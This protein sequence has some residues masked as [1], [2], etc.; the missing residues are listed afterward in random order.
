[1]TNITIEDI[2][3][4]TV[5]GTGVFD[6][7]MNAVKEHIKE[8]Y[9]NGRIK[10]TDYAQVYLGAL[11]GVLGQSVEYV[12]REK[13]TEAQ[14]EGAL[15]DI[16]LKEAQIIGSGYDNQVKQQQVAESVFR[17]NNMLPKELEQIT[18]QI[19]QITAQIEDIA[20]G[21][22][23]KDMQKQIAYVERVIKDKEATTMGL[24]N[25]IRL[26]EEARKQD[27]NYV[28][29]PVYKEIG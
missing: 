9:A 22:E 13:L 28:Y 3:T 7:L 1:M 18:A 11:Q 8:E 24:D 23:I 25:A 16:V 15:K 29:V 26:R 20:K 4:G 12:L 5:D 10:G 27:T 14:V 17:V 6:K 19:E 2:T 21:I